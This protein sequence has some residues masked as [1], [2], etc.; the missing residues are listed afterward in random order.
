MMRY[1]GLDG[2]RGIGAISIVAYHVFIIGA[3][4]GYNGFFDYTVG[5]FGAFVRAFFILSSFSLMCGY[6]DKMDKGL[7][8]PEKFYVRRVT[9]L[10]PVLFVAIV[11]HW[12]IN[13]IINAESSIWNIIGTGTLLFGLMPS[14][15]ESFVWAGWALGLEVIFYLMFPAFFVANKNKKRSWIFF[16]I[17]IVLL[18]AYLDFYGLGVTNS[19]INIIRQLC[20]FALGGLLYHYALEVAELGKVGKRF[21]LAICLSIE[22][23]GFVFLKKVTGDLVLLM[24][25]GSLIMNQV[26]N[27][28]VL[29]N[30]RLTRFLGKI[31][32]EIYLLHMVVY[33]CLELTD[34]RTVIS[35]L[36]NGKIRQF[37]LHY[38]IVAGI[39]VLVAWGIHT[40]FSA[41]YILKS[42]SE[43]NC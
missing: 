34:I 17:S 31:S 39:S 27:K 4:Q 38:A 5:N 19:H 23:F 32:Y 33:R 41:K 14:N 10:V 6:A 16:G 24:V 40:L 11:A 3:Y 25:F 30:N 36:I 21:L 13:T 37:V 15:Q 20:Y 35:G 42:K 7:F 12:I 29:V 26:A 8:D 22:V 9:K 43:R 28:D 2:I 1:E 18:F